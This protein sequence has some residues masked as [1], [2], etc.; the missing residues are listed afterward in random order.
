MIYKKWNKYFDDNIKII[1]I[2]LAGRGK[3]MSE[4]F[5][6]DMGSAIDDAYKI[7]SPVIKDGEYA[8]FGH[9]MGSI[10]AFELCHRVIR[11]K[12]RQP[13]HLFVSGRY[14]PDV[15]E[16]NRHLSKL[17]D[18]EFQQE[19]LKLGG[20]DKEVFNNKELCNIFIPILKADYRIIEDYE[21]INR[22]QKFNYGITVFNGRSDEDVTYG[23]ALE[24][25]KHTSVGS[26]IYEFDGGHFFIND[27]AEEI[28][29]IIKK[30]I[31]DC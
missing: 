22:N 31:S 17:P 26:S 8:F 7:A 28:T 2:E 15:L 20:T 23:D 21:Y 14:P 19:I 24:W 13:M 29:D 4:K 18:D 25:G 16:K 9:S 12:E 27:K 6:K 30:T 5:Y 11:E 1:P 10:I 3:R